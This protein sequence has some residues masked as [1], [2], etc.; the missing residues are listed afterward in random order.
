MPKKPRIAILSIDGGGIRGIIPAQVLA[1]LEK[2][3]RQRCPGCNLIDYFDY[4]AGTSTGG[5]IVSSLLCPKKGSSQPKFTSEDICELYE[6]SGKDIFPEPLVNIS[7][8]YNEKYSRAGLEDILNDKFAKTEL[9]HLLKP[10]LITSY[11]VSG[12]ETFFFRQHRAVRD[13]G[14]NYLLSDVCIATSAAP[15]YFEAAKIKSKSDVEYT[16]V[17]GGV[18]MNN[19]VLGAYSDIRN[20]R[21]TVKKQGEDELSVDNLR[22]KDMFVVSL[23]TGSVKKRYT[24]EQIKDWGQVKWAEPIIDILTSGSSETID[25]ITRQIFEGTGFNDSYIRLDTKDLQDAD[26][27][28]DNA[29]P[30]NIRKLVQAGKKLAAANNELLD[31]LAAF[32]IENRNMA[33]IQ[34]SFDQKKPP[35]RSLVV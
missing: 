8:I 27:D 18:V 17:D 28:L 5:I 4:F 19:P 26:P 32:L 25:Y 21:L 23:G 6:K 7:P 20:A 33:D 9:K 34:L 14:Y 22:A 1:A 10:C 13:E 35:K 12:R 16:L 11:D 15:T 30:E 29:R 24:Y 3:L 2:K 31:K